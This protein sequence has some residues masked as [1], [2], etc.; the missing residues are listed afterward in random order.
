MYGASGF[1]SS[2]PAVI[3]KDGVEKVLIPELSDDEIAAWKK[4]CE[5]VKG[6][7]DQLDWLKVDA[8]VE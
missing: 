4:S 5:H 1:Y 8:R 6:N 2:L 7:I 3:G